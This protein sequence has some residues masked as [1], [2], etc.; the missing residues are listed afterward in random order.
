MLRATNSDKTVEAV[1]PVSNFSGILP[2]RVNRN[3]KSKPFPTPN[4]P[5]IRSQFCNMDPATAALNWPPS[6][7]R[8][9]FVSAKRRSLWTGF[10]GGG[11]DEERARQR[12]LTGT[13]I[14]DPAQKLHNV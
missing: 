10:L 7:Q 3:R 1:L 4:L 2:S 5:E 12:V 13:T 8:I 14:G 9:N 11:Q 6:K